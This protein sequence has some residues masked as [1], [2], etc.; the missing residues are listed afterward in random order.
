MAQDSF[1]MG[2][3][4]NGISEY[5]FIHAEAERLELRAKRAAVLRLRRRLRR[6][7]REAWLM[8]RNI[9][10]AMRK[11]AGATRQAA[12]PSLV[13]HVGGAANLR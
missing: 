5:E 11:R 7:A 10:A 1:T 3:L 6:G 8:T 4:G 13:L 9:V 12:A 2:M